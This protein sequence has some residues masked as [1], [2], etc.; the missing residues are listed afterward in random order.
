MHIQQQ[1]D[2]LKAARITS[3]ND[4]FLGLR[5]GTEPLN[6]PRPIAAVVLEA[7]SLA[8]ADF[9][10]NYRVSEI[11]IDERDN[12]SPRAYRM[13]AYQIVEYA[14]AHRLHQAA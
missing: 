9:G 14:S 11:Q 6:D 4:H 10:T 1:C 13:M 8:N 2:W 5:F 3:L 12:Y 7:V